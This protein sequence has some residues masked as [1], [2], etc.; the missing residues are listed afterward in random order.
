M[1]SFGNDG[2]SIGSK[3]AALLRMQ[4]L[5]ETTGVPE[6]M[7]LRYVRN[8]LLPDPVEDGSNSALFHPDCVERIQFVETMQRRHG[9]PLTKV[10]RLLT[11][12]DQGTDA[13]HRTELF[14]TVFGEAGGTLVGEELFCQATGLTHRQ[15]HDLIDAQ[16]LLPVNPGAFDQEDVALGTLYAGTLAMGLSVEDLSFYPGLGRKMV[17]AEMALRRRVT[18]CASGEVNVEHTLQLVQATRAIRTYVTDRV[19]Q[20][21]IAQALTF[22]TGEFF[23]LNIHRLFQSQSAAGRNPEVD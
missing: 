13:R 15:F 2:D 8:G 9:L 16:L 4:D 22:V 7:I 19:F 14:E 12:K 3:S 23:A 17:D 1:T 6:S 18:Q 5:V 21:R 10:K 20:K 11:L